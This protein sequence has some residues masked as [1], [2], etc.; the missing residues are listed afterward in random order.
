MPPPPCQANLVLGL[1]KKVELFAESH[2]PHL[3]PTKNGLYGTEGEGGAEDE[4]G[5]VA[6]KDAYIYKVANR[7]DFENSTFKKV[8]KLRQGYTNICIRCGC[9][10]YKCDRG[11]GAGCKVEVANWFG[12][13]LPPSLTC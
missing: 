6:G 7:K 2:R 9:K 13:D 5:A 4:R 8:R 1:G 10:A 3:P 12:G 11:V